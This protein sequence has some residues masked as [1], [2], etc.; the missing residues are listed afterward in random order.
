MACSV[1]CWS[2][3]VSVTPDTEPLLWGFLAQKRSGIFQSSR[4]FELVKGESRVEGLSH[5]PAAPFS[6]VCS[7]LAVP[8]PV[9]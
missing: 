7:H 2:N 6:L 5:S 3:K 1:L 9:I 4:V 8:H